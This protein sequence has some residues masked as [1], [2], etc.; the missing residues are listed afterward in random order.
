[1]VFA[2]ALAVLNP[3]DN[4]KL[5]RL[6]PGRP[7]SADIRPEAVTPGASMSAG[8]ESDEAPPRPREVADVTIVIPAYNERE[9]LPP[10]LADIR[11]VLERSAPCI[12]SVIVVDDGSTDETL[13]WLRQL[14]A[15]WPQL[16]V[17]T[18]GGNRGKGAAV[19]AGVLASESS[20]V[21]IA[22]ADGA[23]PI[24]ELAALQEAIYG[25]ADVACGSRTIGLGARR[26]WMRKRIGAAFSKCVALLTRLH[27]RDTQCG[28][29]LFR[30]AS[31]RKLFSLGS[32]HG[33][34]FDIEVLILADLMRLRVVEIPVRWTEV[35]GSKVRVWR[36]G[37][38]MLY[39]LIGLRRRTRMRFEAGYLDVTP[40]GMDVNVTA[41][42][43]VLSGPTTWTASHE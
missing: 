3:H 6:P 35:A 31:A 10:F 13:S 20:L 15:S 33:F 18:L 21:L 23:T 22:D 43:S 7:T 16:N 27:V 37:R 29:K 34:L 28:F 12:Y 36:D 11:R 17:I 32:E 30:G 25:G 39:D 38:E 40:G 5:S 19:R 26:A 41:S 14:A 8:S 24:T 2:R 9:R 4:P 1:M 42:G